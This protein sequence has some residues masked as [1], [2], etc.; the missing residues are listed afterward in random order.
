MESIFFRGHYGGDFGEVSFLRL[1]NF[2]PWDIPGWKCLV[3][4]GGGGNLC[5]F[6]GVRRDSVNHCGSWEILEYLL[7]S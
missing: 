2:Y 6:S 3:I 4:K 1:I 7:N 5:F